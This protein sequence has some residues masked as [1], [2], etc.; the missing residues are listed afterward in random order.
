[1]ERLTGKQAQSLAEAY[2]AVYTSQELTE[3]QVWEEV[4]SGLIHF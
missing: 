1:M 4:E 3:E 2:A